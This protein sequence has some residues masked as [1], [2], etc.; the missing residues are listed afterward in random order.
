MELQSPEVEG[1]RGTILEGM[2]ERNGLDNDLALSEKIHTMTASG[3][4]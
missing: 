2:G 3:Q 1:T 4:T